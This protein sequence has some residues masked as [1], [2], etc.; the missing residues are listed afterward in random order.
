[1]SKKESPGTASGGPGTQ[2][3]PINPFHER[4]RLLHQQWLDAK[5]RLALA[6]EAD[7]TR[8]IRKAERAIDDAFTEFYEANRGLI[9]AV[10]RTWRHSGDQ[11]DH[12]YHQDGAEA[13]VQVFQNWNPDR[14]TFGTASRQPIN[15]KVK[16]G[17]QQCIA[18]DL[19]YGTFTARSPIR[20]AEAELTIDGILPTDEEIADHLTRNGRPTTAE[21]VQVARRGRAASLDAQ[22]G[23]DGGVLGDIVADDTASSAAAA[24]LELFDSPSDNPYVL[25]VRAQLLAMFQTITPRQLYAFAASNGLFGLEVTNLKIAAMTGLGRELIRREANR[26]QGKLDRRFGLTEDYEPAEPEPMVTELDGSDNSC[27]ATCDDT[28]DLT[29]SF[30]DDEEYSWV[31]GTL[32]ASL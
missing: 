18:P 1:M 11:N 4:N 24:A 28:E 23:S 15:G 30:A 6:I 27:D 17:V 12:D 10:T 32:F 9:G 13:V 21:T 31:A 25:Q 26:V 5:D 14:A 22:M 2:P 7:D 8:A 16:R 19:T 29:E 3:T 20:V